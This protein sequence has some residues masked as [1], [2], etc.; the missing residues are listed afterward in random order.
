MRNSVHLPANAVI[1]VCA[2]GLGAMPLSL[3]GRPPDSTAMEVIRSFVDSGGQ[4]IDTANV[5]CR[6]EQEVGHNENLVFRGLK[7]FRHGDVYIA[8]KGGL[9]MSGDSWTVDGSPAW[10]RMS[11]ENSLMN[12]NTASI[13]LYQLH[14]PDPDIDLLESVGE[15]M[16]MQSEGMIQHIGISNVTRKQLRRVTEMTT[17]FS[18]QNRCNLFHR[19]DIDQGLVAMCRENNILYIAHSPVGGHYNHANLMGN[20]I[21]G[22]VAGKHGTTSYCIALAW[23]L[24]QGDNI[25]PIPGASKVQSIQNSL[26]ARDI[27]LD[28]ED[29]N[30]LEKLKI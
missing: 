9:R 15:L 16:R 1:D 26:T 2:I 4:F 19:E 14:A 25:L 29:V 8:T 18:V 30:E 17:V 3:R 21:L 11:C 27:T 5:Y 20:N 6:N 12:L 22:R 24:H 7:D 23:L 28:E 10:L 13:F